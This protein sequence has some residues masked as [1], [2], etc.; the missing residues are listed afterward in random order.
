M[1]SSGSRD[2]LGASRALRLRPGRDRSHGRVRHLFP[3]WTGGR[4]RARR[5]GWNVRS[6][7]TV[8]RGCEP[9][10]ADPHD[11]PGA[12]RNPDEIPGP[13][14]RRVGRS[15]ARNG[16]PS[17]ALAMAR[18]P[19]RDAPN[20][21]LRSSAPQWGTD[22]PP[23]RRGRDQRR[24]DRRRSGVRGC[25]RRSGP[26]A[27]VHDHTRRADRGSRGIVRPTPQRFRRA[28]EKRLILSGWNVSSGS[29]PPASPGP[30][31]YGCWAALAFALSSSFWP[32]MW[33]KR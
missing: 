18:V 7:P 9:L 8:H 26:A 15:H 12:P 11:P 14:S 21:G 20:S 22:R 10:G 30:A 2:R 31:D 17:N 27:P 16:D 19:A 33:A 13:R 4:D 6:G 1:G 32:R 28:R 24:L 29:A 3:D 23:R 25:A 5:P